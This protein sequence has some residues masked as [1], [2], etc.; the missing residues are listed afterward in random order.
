MPATLAH[1]PAVLKLIYGVERDPVVAEAGEGYWQPTPPPLDIPIE[2]LSDEMAD[3]A[4]PKLRVFPNGRVAGVVA[5]EG[6]CL[7]DGSGDCWMVPRPADGRGS[8]L[9]A[10]NTDDGDYYMAHT[11]STMT[12]Q[13]EVATATLAGPGGHANGY[14]GPAQ[15]KKYYDDADWQVCRGRYVWSDKAG[16]LCF[17]GALY[18]WV[19]DRQIATIRASACSVDYRYVED[20][21]QYRLVA[22]CLVNVGGL[23][24]RYAALADEGFL[25]TA[26]RVLEL[27][28]ELGLPKVASAGAVTPAYEGMVI[29]HVFEQLAER[30]QERDADS[31]RTAALPS[32]REAAEEDPPMRVKHG[33]RPTIVAAPDDGGGGGGGAATAVADAAATEPEVATGTGPQPCVDCDDTDTTTGAAQQAAAGG[34][35]GGTEVSQKGSDGTVVRPAATEATPGARTAAYELEE[36]PGGTEGFPNLPPNLY[37]GDQLQWGDGQVGMYCDPFLTVDGQTMVAVYP[38]EG[39]VLQMD[40]PVLMAVAE[41]TQTGKFYSWTE[42]SW[43]TVDNMVITDPDDGPAAPG[44]SEAVVSRDGEPA[45][46]AAAATQARDVPSVGARLA[47]GRVPQGAAITPVEH[48]LATVQEQAQTRDDQILSMLA[49]LGETVGSLTSTVDELRQEHLA[50][51]IAEL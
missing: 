33:Q 2:W 17:V 37:Y 5:P 22:T 28:A 34:G 45:G 6:R 40:R 9:C 48:R 30:A 12:D 35:D 18:P 4:P 51:E 19:T 26:D 32:G 43:Q 14:V 46:A 11:G 20:E 38:E 47:A 42:P 7:L 10:P 16:G 8:R 1:P 41:V 27:A 25:L 29:D 36:I 21:S 50:R 39:Q 44:D 23:P 15:A 31:A 24:S 3:A 13:G 49:S